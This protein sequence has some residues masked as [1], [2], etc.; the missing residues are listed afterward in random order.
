MMLWDTVE[1]SDVSELP[2]SHEQNEL[3]CWRGIQGPE[4]AGTGVVEELK[5]SREWSH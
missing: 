4:H 2:P 1:L 5:A 3:P